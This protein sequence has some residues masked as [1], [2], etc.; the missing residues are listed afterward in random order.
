METEIASENS[1]EITATCESG[2]LH[3]TLDLLLSEI[4][5]NKA[6]L[7]DNIFRKN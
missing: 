1:S 3:L 6:L 4:Q 7:K 2:P 5:N